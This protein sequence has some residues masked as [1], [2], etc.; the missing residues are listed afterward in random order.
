MAMLHATHSPEQGGEVLSQAPGA[1]NGAAI[2][3]PYEH[4]SGRARWVAKFGLGFLTIAVIVGA[5][6]IYTLQPGAN[7]TLTPPPSKVA[8]ALWTAMADGSLVTNI[9]WSLYRV[10]V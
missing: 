2:A 1:V 9:G 5:Y 3:I 4:S 7:Q 10:V 6:W 8:A